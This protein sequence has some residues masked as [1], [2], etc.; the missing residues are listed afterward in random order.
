MV[1]GPFPG[2]VTDMVVWSVLNSV[3]DE[4]VL[5][6]VGT[7]FAIR[8]RERRGVTA[9]GCGGVGWTRERV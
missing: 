7:T 9:F 6:K 2:L 8:V 4:S 5:A 1:A 3:L